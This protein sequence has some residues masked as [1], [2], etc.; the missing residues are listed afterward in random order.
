MSAGVR[1]TFGML[2]IV[3]TLAGCER[4]PA[5]TVAPTR[6]APLVVTRPAPAP[7]ATPKPKPKP[8]AKAKPKATRTQPRRPSYV[9]TT[10]RRPRATT[11]PRK[12]P[13]PTL[14]P[15]RPA[16]VAAPPPATAAPPPATAAPPAP[17]AAPPALDLKALEQ[18][19]R[20]THAIG[21]FT[22]L[23]L[24]N[25]VDDLLAQFR[26]VYG[27]RSRVSMATLH[28]HYDLLLMKVLSLLQNSDPNLAARI[29]ASR[30]AIWKI[31]S[32]PKKFAKI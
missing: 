22:K 5:A 2:L 28:Q 3:A 6:A 20:D 9:A 11:H 31:L 26:A 8:K 30:G 16:V 18:R 1:A 29:A 14:V 17:V 7:V 10:L 19:L 24:K 12:P 13:A 25:E 32:D 21:L 4:R 23:S 27:G 15:S